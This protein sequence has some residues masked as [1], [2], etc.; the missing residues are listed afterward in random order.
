[1]D[2]RLDGLLGHMQRKI[3][4]LATSNFTK[5]LPVC[6]GTNL[7]GVPGIGSCEQPSHDEKFVF[8]VDLKI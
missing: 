2:K 1:L 4:A 3:S 8:G 6:D 7:L 5:C